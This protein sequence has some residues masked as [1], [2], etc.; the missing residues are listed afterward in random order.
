MGT[1]AH[2]LYRVSIQRGGHSGL[3]TEPAGRRAVYCR[4]KVR[5]GLW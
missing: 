5:E 3:V 1:D 4:E 2:N